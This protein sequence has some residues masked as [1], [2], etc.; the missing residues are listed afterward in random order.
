MY[1]DKTLEGDAEDYGG[2]SS[3]GM[4]AEPHGVE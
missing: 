1:K 4:L 3:H 2:F